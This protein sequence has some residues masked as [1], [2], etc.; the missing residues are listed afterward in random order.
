MLESV[1]VEGI[2][3]EE[4]ISQSLTSHHPSQ[5]HPSQHHRPQPYSSEVVLTAA[6]LGISQERAAEALKAI[7][8][9]KA[10]R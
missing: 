8:R 3:N 9:K 4:S 6:L 5:H 2:G 10:G 7:R 1:A